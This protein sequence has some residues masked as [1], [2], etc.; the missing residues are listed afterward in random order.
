MSFI[1]TGVFT[2]QNANF[3]LLVQSIS[4]TLD[5]KEFSKKYTR[6]HRDQQRKGYLLW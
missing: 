5:F 4:W 2:V 6:A 3:L 1:C